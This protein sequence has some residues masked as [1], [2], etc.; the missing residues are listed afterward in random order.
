MGSYK[1][2]LKE[3]ETLESSVRTLT[4]ANSPTTEE[5]PI[6]DNESESNAEV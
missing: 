2:L 1:H 3:K 6:D 4:E 5:N